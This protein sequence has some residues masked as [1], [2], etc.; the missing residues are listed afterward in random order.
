[1]HV[2]SSQA[3]NGA[4]ALWSLLSSRAAQASARSSSTAASNFSADA[5]TSSTAASTAATSAATSTQASTTPSRF[6]L[7]QSTTQFAGCHRGPPPGEDPIAS[8]DADTNGSVSAEEF[9]LDGASDEVKA[10]F[11]AI[12]GDGSGDLSTDEIDSFREQMMAA[13]QAAGGPPMGPPPGPPP[14]ASPSGSSEEPTTDSTASA[15]SQR[16]SS[17]ASMDVGAFIQQL[18]SRYASLAGESGTASLL[19]ASA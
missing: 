9:G 3:S 14:G 19:S 7:A 15:A 6:E 8:L 13:D 17:S 2:S 10:L 16:S 5:S 1:M 4:S 11:Q 18:A 12:D